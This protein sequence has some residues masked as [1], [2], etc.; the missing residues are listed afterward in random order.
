MHAGETMHCQPCYNGKQ[1]I[2]G[3]DNGLF[4]GRHQAI[5]WT[6]AGMMLIGPIGTNFSGILTGIQTFFIKEKCRLWNGVHFVLAT[7]C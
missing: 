4:P 5:I 1:T 2:I 3:L 6:N 7:M